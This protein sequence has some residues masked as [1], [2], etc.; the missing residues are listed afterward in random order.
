MKN[1]IIKYTSEISKTTDFIQKDLE[2]YFRNIDYEKSS[3]DIHITQIN[4]EE[5]LNQII[6]GVGFYIIL[7]DH[8]FNDNNCKFEFNSQKAIYRG[9]SHYSKKRLL[10]HLANEKYNRN[11][12][13]NEPNYKV[14]LKIENGKN[15]ININQIP[16]KNWN[17]TVIVHKMK[18][19]SKLMREQAE[20]AF[21]KV[22]NKP[23]KSREN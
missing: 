15:G 16:Y 6:F 19:S 23:C 10:S 21:D 14:C 8:I 4:N 2:A 17:W 11:R 1:R 9:H 18:G 13:K 20:Q 5:D 12:K 7:T 3:K 22:Y